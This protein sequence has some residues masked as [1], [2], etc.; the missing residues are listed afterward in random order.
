MPAADAARRVEILRSI[1][2]LP[3]HIAGA[4]LSPIGFQ[5]ADNGTYYVF[6]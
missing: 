6:D 4:F 3:A 1:S 2:G 5:Q